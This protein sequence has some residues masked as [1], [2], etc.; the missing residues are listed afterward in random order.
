MDGTNN[1]FEIMG[2]FDKYVSE[3]TNNANAYVPK[4]DMT[5]EDIIDIP[6]E[7]LMSMTSEECISMSF[8]VSGY[9]MYIR[10]QLNDNNARLNW[11]EDTLNRVV[12]EEYN[13]F[14]P[15]MKYEIRRQA[16]IAQNSFT[17]K[18]EKLRSRLKA[19]TTVLEDKLRDIR[20]MADTLKDLGR[21]KSYHERN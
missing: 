20:D 6:Y 1:E 7:K 14:D 2:D 5:V 21:T 13:S 11:C 17:F 16:I 10:G 12:A 4:L 8:K 9:A 15:Y 18:V 3:F 19:R